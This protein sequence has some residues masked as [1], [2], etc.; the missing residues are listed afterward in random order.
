M[1]ITDENINYDIKFCHHRFT[2]NTHPPTYDSE[3]RV[4]KEGENVN[5]GKN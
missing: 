4:E 1:N 3:K 5:N 2:P